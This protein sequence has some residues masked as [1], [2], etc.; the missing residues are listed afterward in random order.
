M[1]GN[2]C[3]SI[4]ALGVRPMPVYYSTLIKFSS[5]DPSSAAPYVDHLR[6]FLNSEYPYQSIASTVC[7]LAACTA[8]QGGLGAVLPT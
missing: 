2:A 5:G 4:S 6:A 8:L 7:L 3:T 1:A